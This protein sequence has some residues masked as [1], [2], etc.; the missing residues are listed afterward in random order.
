M[1]ASHAPRTRAAYSYTWMIFARWCEQVGGQALPATPE[2]VADF[3]VWSLYERQPPYRL[4][5]VQLTLYAISHRH[6]QE[7]LPSPLTD[8]V[9][10]LVRNAKRDLR[11][12]PQYAQAL[13]PAELR[14]ICR[15]LCTTVPIDIRDRALILTQ[16][17][18][19]WRREEIASLDRCDVRFMRKGF[20]LSLGASKTDQDGSEGR[21]VAIEYGAHAVTCPV[22]ALREWLDIRG[23]WPGPLFCAM[24]GGG[25][26]PQRLSGDAINER[27]KLAVAR[28]GLPA[29]RYSS[30]SL[31]AGMVTAA[32]ERGAPETLIMLRTGHKSLDSMRRY[33]R[34]AKACRFNVLQGVL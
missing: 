20:L 5:T 27:F 2:T 33:V 1:K 30:H 18:A 19:G 31:R 9:K 21:I 32:I 8:N 12:R 17:A 24:Y 13:E 11:E 23:T 3:V 14:R 26:H 16:F 4:Q 25:I 22:R 10:L 34:P 15:Q 7:H 6:Q 28:A 29:A